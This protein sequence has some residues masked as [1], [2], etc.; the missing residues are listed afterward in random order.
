MELSKALYDPEIFKLVSLE[1]YRDA[2][3]DGQ[4][5]SKDIVSMKLEYQTFR[6]P[7]VVGGWY[8]LMASMIA[9]Y[10]DRPVVSLDIS[11]TATKVAG[12]V[13]GARGTAIQAD[14]FNFDY[15]GYDLVVNTST[16]HFTRP[17]S[18]WISMLA[19]GTLVVLQNNDDSSIPDH[20]QS[21]ATK[22]EFQESVKLSE[23]LECL[24]V[25]FPQYK[26]HMIVGRT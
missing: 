8:G 2:M 19:K 20:V 4:L 21:F 22:E 1:E 9:I 18:E 10:H 11:E 24:T 12:R 6:K 14:A 26:R 17:L 16:E 3:S 5:V 7:V 25:E 13:L 23:V 15:K